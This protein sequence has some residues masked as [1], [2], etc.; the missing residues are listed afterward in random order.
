M[1]K[2]GVIAVS[3]SESKLALWHSD[4]PHLKTIDSSSAFL[5]SRPL[6]KHHISPLSQRSLSI[7]FLICKCRESLKRQDKRAKRE[8]DLQQQRIRRLLAEIKPELGGNRPG[9]EVNRRKRFLQDEVYMSHTE[10]RRMISENRVKFKQARVL[11][12]G[13]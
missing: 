4:E 3:K 8:L 9:F 5:T 6:P 7:D 12:I 13:S 1:M 2:R 10:V 11:S